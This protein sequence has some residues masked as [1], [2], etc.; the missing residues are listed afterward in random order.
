GFYLANINMGATESLPEGQK[1][2]RYFPCVSSIEPCLVIRLIYLVLLFMKFQLE[3]AKALFK[4]VLLKV[5]RVY[6]L[7]LNLALLRCFLNSNAKSFP[8]SKNPHN[9]W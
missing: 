6:S 4:I 9:A 2:N 8:E 5:K 1:L 7:P 3:S